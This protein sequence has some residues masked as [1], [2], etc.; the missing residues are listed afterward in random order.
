MGQKMTKSY[1]W[2]CRRQVTEKL[3]T[4]RTSPCPQGSYGE[5]A[6]KSCRVMTA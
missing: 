6:N 4:S 2:T 1:L 5:V 3:M